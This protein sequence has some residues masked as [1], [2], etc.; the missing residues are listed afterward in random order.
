M[1]RLPPR[2]LKVERDFTDARL[3]GFGG[4]SALALMAERLG[5]FRDLSEGVRIKARRRGTSDGESLRALVASLAAGGGALSDLDILR[6]D[7]AARRLL[8]LS[9]APSGRRMGEFLAKRSEAD[10]A[11][12]LEAARRARGCRAGLCPRVRGR[13]GDRGGL[14]VVRRAGHS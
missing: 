2:P 14:G 3:T 4:W 1:N 6:A 7:P 12:L 10:L 13:H 9:H 8:G 11:S 5:L